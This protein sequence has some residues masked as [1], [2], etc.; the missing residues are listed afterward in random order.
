MKS[1][2][3]LI[4]MPGSGKSFFGKRLIEHLDYMLIDLDKE[5]ESREGRS[6]SEIFEK[7]GE[8]YFRKVEAELL[9]TITSA[10][11]KLILSTGGGTPCFHDGMAFM[12]ENGITVFLETVR[13]Q[14]IERLAR[15]SHRP[16][17]RGDVEK[18]VNDLLE[19][20][21]Q[22]YGQADI[23]ISH[24][25]PKLLLNKIEVLNK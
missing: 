8:E 14:L 1:K 21:M 5:I 9:R 19:K 20:R 3:F 17:I 16:L 10:N 25:D 18:S 15:K 12:N 11:E 22:F 2:I 23:S 6:I 7:E 24:R 4:G 13:E